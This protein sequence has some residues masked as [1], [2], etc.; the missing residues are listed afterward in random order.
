M[1]AQHSAFIYPADM[2]KIFLIDDDED[3]QLLFK[4][5]IELINPS[6]QCETAGNGK[7]ALEKL[8]VST[9]LPDLIFLDL[10]MPIM[11]GY[12]FLTHIKMERKLSKV[13]ICI[14][15]TSNTNRDMKMTKEVGASFFLAKQSDFKILCNQLKQ[16][17]I[18]D[19]PA[20]EYIAI[21]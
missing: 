18:A 15:T 1:K 10:N 6:L 19:L 21:K 12:E 7:I 16:L 3:D 2:N 4:E 11:N 5:A 20:D 9:T 14:Y 17:L 13:P 8:K